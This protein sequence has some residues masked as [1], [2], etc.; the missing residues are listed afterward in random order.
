MDLVKKKK[1]SL[2]LVLGKTIKGLVTLDDLRWK[3]GR[4]HSNERR[5]SSQGLH[6]R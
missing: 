1:P 5:A 6:S 4:F 3:M 2:S